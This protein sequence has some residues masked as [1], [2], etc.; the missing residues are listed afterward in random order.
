MFVEIEN[1]TLKPK[2]NKMQKKTITKTEAG[3]RKLGSALSKP[4]RNTSPAQSPS[5]EEIARRAYEIYLARGQTGGRE[6]ED[7][8][9]AERELV[10]Q[11]HR[12]N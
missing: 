10:A 12:N 5:R 4:E 6:V 9:Q 11:S 1:G 2:A 7:W 8:V 3:G